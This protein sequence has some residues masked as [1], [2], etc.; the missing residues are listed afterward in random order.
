MTISE[1][2]EKDGIQGTSIPANILVVDNDE[3]TLSQVKRFVIKPGHNAT[4]VNN[5]DAAIGIIKKQ[6]PDLILLDVL[7][8]VKSGDE[9]LKV[10]KADP[11]LCNIPVVM[12]TVI[13]EMDRVARCIKNGA[14]D[15]IVKPIN[16]TLFES[17]LS[18]FIGKK[19]QSD[20]EQS[21]YEALSKK[22]DSPAEARIHIRKL[23]YAIER[24]P[25]SVMV[26]DVKGNIEYVN[27]KFTVDTGY[28]PEE[29]IGKNPRLLKSSEQPYS[30]YIKLWSTI[31][32]GYEWKGRFYNK[33]KDGS[34]YQAY[35]TIGPVKNDKGDIVSFVSV[36]VEDTEFVKLADEA[37][38]NDHYFA[39]ILEVSED[40]VISMNEDQRITIF[41]KGAERIFGYTSDEIIGESIE[42]LIP[43]RY[44]SNHKNHVRTFSKS[45]KNS[46]RLNDRHFRLFG[47]NRDGEEFPAEISISKFKEDGKVVFT[48][49]LRD[50]TEQ[51]KTEEELIKVQKLESVGILAG[52]IAHDFNNI[53]TA[54]M[55]NA[56]L[57]VMFVKSNDSNKALKVLSIIE[58]ASAR[59]ANLT[60][61]LITFAK[62]GVPV[63]KLGSVANLINN[64]VSFANRGTNVN[65]EIIIRKGLWH[66]EMDEGQMNQVI[67]NLVINA[68]QAMPAGGTLTVNAK[69]ITKDEAVEIKFLKPVKYVLISIKDV[70]VGIPQK[71]I[72]KVFDPY[73]TT[74]EMRSGLGLASSYAIVN[75]HGG[76]LTVESEVNKGSVFHIYLPASSDEIIKPRGHEKTKLSVGRGKILVMDD[77]EEVRDMTEMALGLIGYEVTCVKDGDEALKLYSNTRDNGKTYDVTIM[78]LTV[79]GGMGGKD[80]IA[81]LLEI[82]PEANAIVFS[83]YSGDPI[84]S[85]YKDYGFKGVISKPF[86]IQEMNELLQKVIHGRTGA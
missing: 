40:A 43:E 1:F 82:H 58:K 63:M 61:Q 44:R 67:T 69:N 64:A 72:R 62:G 42:L 81:K 73:Y 29:V 22:S 12:I 48:A 75:K 74:K 71:N 59:A 39:G 56:G 47:V 51:R 19:R 28:T 41:N 49:V 20:N 65:N 55:G 86:Q 34:H 53:L 8:T 3:T 76:L 70:G 13:D 26:T 32:A 80:T 15:Y 33:R 37:R 79:P 36:K 25:V 35:Q 31:I 6:K 27:A 85:N 21:F 7:M 78:D 17:R 68:V 52:G 9:V 46:I 83:G 38:K 14:D 50:I 60:K 77:S 11:L 4:L 66:V 54:I 45:A 10:L 5:G 57:G 30:F 16:E 23:T 84:M 18:Y 24:C 2:I